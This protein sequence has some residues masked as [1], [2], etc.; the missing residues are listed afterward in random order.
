MATRATDRWTFEDYFAWEMEQPIR[1]E[2]ID[3]DVYAMTA[4]TLRH[5]RVIVNLIAALHSGLRGRRGT[6]FQGDAK[7]SIV[8]TGNSYY[9]DALVC[10]DPAAMQ[11]RGVVTDATVVV[12]VLSPSTA[13]FNLKG[14]FAEYPPAAGSATLSRDRS[15]G[16]DLRPFCTGRRNLDDDRGRERR[17]RLDRDR[18]RPVTVRPVRRDRR[19]ACSDRPPAANVPPR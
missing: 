4:G 8:A 5:S 2:F 1:H 15:G 19:A 3:G 7:L 16:P 18:C 11:E 12:E 10:C 6:L 17:D 9:P 14:K 13:A